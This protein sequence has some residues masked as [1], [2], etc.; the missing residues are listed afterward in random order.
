MGVPTSVEYVARRLSEL[1]IDR[2]FC[3]PG[4]H[5]FPIDDE[6]ESCQ[7]L[8]WIGCAN[9][10]NAA[11]GYAV[12]NGAAILSTTCGAEEC[13]QTNAN[14]SRFPLHKGSLIRAEAP[15]LGERGGRLVDK[16]SRLEGLR[17]D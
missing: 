3:I 14:S 10:R 7:L 9:E 15:P 1:G 8:K 2:V 17:P 16:L 5:A 6:V 13:C 4:G 11:D 12:R